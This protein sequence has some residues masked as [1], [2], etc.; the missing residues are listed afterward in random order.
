MACF[1]AEAY[2]ANPVASRAEV[3]EALRRAAEEIAAEGTFVRYIRSIVVPADETCFHL[4][5]A[6]SAAAV[7]EASALARVTCMRVVEAVE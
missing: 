2:N 3:E 6:P 5:E 4:F 1:I 7:R